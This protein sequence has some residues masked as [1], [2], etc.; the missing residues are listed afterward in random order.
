MHDHTQQA[1][2]ELRAWQQRMQAKPGLFSKL[3][4]R[5]QHKANSLIPERIHQAIT[6]LIKQMVRAVLTGS[7][8]TTATPLRDALFSERETRVLQKIKTYR[9]TAMVEGGVTGAGGFLLALSDFPLLLTIKLKLLFEIAALYGHATEDYRERIYLLLIFQLTFSSPT[10]RRATYLKILDWQAHSK[11]LPESMHEFDWRTFQQEYRDYIDL[12]KLA[13]LLPVVGAP[14]GAVVN[15]R[16][17]K[18]LGHT[19]MNAYRLRW[20]NEHPWNCE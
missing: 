5:I 1:L 13:Q 12:A 4:R 17:L 7:H 11:Q 16:L 8:Y 9:N 15:Y 6:T 10:Q 18:K 19:A 2:Q 3:T 14:V 20:F